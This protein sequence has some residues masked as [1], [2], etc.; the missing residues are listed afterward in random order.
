[1][2]NLP[3]WH[4][5]LLGAILIAYLL[6]GA[7]YATYTPP[8]QVPDEPAHFNYIR[9]LAETRRLPVLDTG[10]YPHAYLEELKE[11]GF[12]PELSIEPV[13]YEAHQPPLYYLL[14]VPIYWLG[15][16]R[17]LPL[18]LLS[19]AFGAI[20]LLVAHR[21]TRSLLPQRPT[22]ALATAAFVAFV[23]MHLA[24]T[25]SVNNDTLAEL[26]LA[27]VAL[28]SI[29]HVKGD[30]DMVERPHTNEGSIG[31][32]STPWK[33]L[34]SLGVLLG[35]VLVT[36]TTAYAAIPVA[37]AAV[38]WAWGTAGQNAVGNRW[39]E[40]GKRLLAAFG[41]ALAISAPLFVRNALVYGWPDILG[42]QWHNSIVVG[43]PGTAEWVA[44]YGW[45]GLLSRFVQFTFKSFWGVFGWM[46]VFLDNRIYLVLALLSGAV[47]LGLVIFLVRWA[48]GLR[49]QEHKADFVI[50]RETAGLLVLLIIWVGWTALQ[51][52]GYNL[53]FVQHQG[54]Y[55]FPALVPIGLA[56]GLGWRIVLEPKVSRGMG[57][58]YT[59]AAM[60]LG[61]STILSGAL[62]PWPAVLMGSVGVALLLWSWLPSRLEALLRLAPYAAL[63][64]LD[65][66]CLFGYV[67]PQLA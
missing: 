45:N 31:R 19:V 7:L 2:G 38:L 11:R 42:L 6:L 4:S 26:L 24:M 25:A 23:P 53:T 50:R 15:G 52:L 67:V 44:T 59:L 65:I 17:L 57:A 20:L 18:R 41:P 46:G 60:A 13:R 12:P 21:I 35:L 3:R 58:A 63:C 22:L 48:K 55:L 62:L 64:V 61:V 36:K 10:D 27:I 8:W 29:E 56:F 40:L 1:M 30:R 16:G 37:L 54:R 28:K 34:V 51:Y 47:V 14:A 43:Q 39:R 32:V 66:V 9:E 5:V 49:S 33:Q